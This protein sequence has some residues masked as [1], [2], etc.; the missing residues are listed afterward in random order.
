[1]K[2][3]EIQIMVLG[4]VNGESAN[5]WSARGTISGRSIP[6]MLKRAYYRCFSGNFQSHPQRENVLMHNRY[7]EVP[8][9][10]LV[11]VA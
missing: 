8:V 3:Y 9:L 5:V 11:E 2:N 4:S 6:A 1:M 10:R 7:H